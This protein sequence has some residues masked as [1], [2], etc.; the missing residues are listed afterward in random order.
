MKALIIDNEKSLREGLA[1]M[2]SIFCDDI[3]IIETASGV[4]TG[5]DKLKTF[6]PDILFLDVELDDGMGMDIMKSIGK[7]NFEVIFITAHNKYAIDAFQFS[8]LDF[9]L[10]PINPEALIA[11][12]EKAKNKLHLNGIERQFQIL[13]EFYSNLNNPN[14]KLIIKDRNS[15]YV[16][17]VTDIIRCESE[18]SYTTFFL[19]NNEQIVSSKP[20]KE[21]E[22]LLDRFGFIRVHQSHLVNKHKITRFD[23]SDLTLHLENNHEVPVAQRKKDQLLDLLSNS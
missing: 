16:V 21:Y 10:K 1:E 8:A 19:I 22:D 5:L 17:K 15:I 7:P 18:N 13:T 4:A 23:K 6:T 9:I 12:V 2:I 14:Q 11:A 3:N 20:I